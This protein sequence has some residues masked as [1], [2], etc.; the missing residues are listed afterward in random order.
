MGEVTKNCIYEF[1]T[2]PSK[3]EQPDA[4]RMGWQVLKQEWACGIK[5]FY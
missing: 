4:H 5:E 3:V 2:C 1:Q